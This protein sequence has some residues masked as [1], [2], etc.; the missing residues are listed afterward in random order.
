MKIRLFF[1]FL[2]FQMTLIAQKST[3]LSK[4]DLTFAGVR[5]IRKDANLSRIYFDIE[6]INRGNRT[7]DLKNMKL[8]TTLSIDTLDSYV[9]G[10]GT[11]GLYIKTTTSTL[12]VN[13]SKILKDWWVSYLDLPLNQY[14]AII[15][16]IDSMDVLDEIKETNNY[17]YFFHG[18]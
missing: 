18:F 5:N 15:L 13:E 7:A 8:Q 12:A 9:F 3:I 10:A 2:L 17:M 6:I 4:P 1:L 14:T 11:G 16:H